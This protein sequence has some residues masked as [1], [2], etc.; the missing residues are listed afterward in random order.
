MYKYM[1][2]CTD[3]GMGMV[4]NIHVDMFIDVVVVIDSYRY[5]VR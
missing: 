3:I 2:T 1:N 5:V 4:M